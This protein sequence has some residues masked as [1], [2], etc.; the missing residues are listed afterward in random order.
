[1]KPSA[2]IGPSEWGRRAFTGLDPTRPAYI[3]PHWKVLLVRP[4]D[5][6]LYDTWAGFASSEVKHLHW[7]ALAMWEQSEAVVVLCPRITEEMSESCPRYFDY[8]QSDV[9]EAFAD[10]QR[11]SVGGASEVRFR[12]EFVLGS[13]ADFGLAVFSGKRREP[14]IVEGFAREYF[15]SGEGR[16]LHDWMV[17]WRNGTLAFTPDAAASQRTTRRSTT[18]SP[19]G[20]QPNRSEE[21][22]MSS[23]PWKSIANE[24][25]LDKLEAK[26]IGTDTVLLTVSRAFI[27]TIPNK[28]T[29][30]VLDEFLCIEFKEF[31]KKGL[32]CNKTMA[33]SFRALQAAGKLQAGFN[34]IDASFPWEGL[35]VPMYKKEVVYDNRETGEQEK[36]LKLYAVA[37]SGFDKALAEFPRLGAA[38]VRRARPAAKKAGRSK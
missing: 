38:P 16:G 7:L 20:S 27:Q 6:G 18:T 21:T 37:P 23:N 34:D 3:A 14:P 30:E 36:H 35:T 15:R 4:L 5:T 2:V 9:H 11:Q 33:A 22:Q 32:R 12:I 29:G 31:P 28:E 17:Q 26:D 19:V 8:W 25:I 13:Y 10:V 24:G 1:M